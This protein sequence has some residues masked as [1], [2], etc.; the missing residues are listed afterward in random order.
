MWYNLQISGG[1][2][3]H[4]YSSP[5]IAIC[6]VG[7]W[8]SNHLR[9]FTELVGKEN[10]I[11]YDTSPMILSSLVAS[12]KAKVSTSL[13]EAI[14]FA[15][16]VVVSCPADRHT[17]IAEQA[18]L[19]GRSVFIEKPIATTEKDGAKIAKLAEEKDVLV[20]VDHILLHHP[21]IKIIKNEIS[22]GKLGNIVYVDMERTH[23]GWRV[24][25]E[26]VINSIALHDIYLVEDMF[27]KITD[28]VSASGIKMA[29]SKYGFDDVTA[30]VKT[31]TGT[32]VRIHAS[33]ATARKQR[34]ISIMGDN[35]TIEWNDVSVAGSGSLVLSDK[36][37]DNDSESLSTATG[38]CELP[39]VWAE[40]LKEAAKDFINSMV[41]GSPAKC[42][43]EDGTRAVKVVEAIRR[44]IK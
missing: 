42:S 20:A 26:D 24:H 33:W 29:R 15:D 27:G 36:Y 8:G 39:Y 3:S 40:P 10:I 34:Y 19:S 9:V 13:D 12:N 4:K 16:G 28:I 25:G 6:G 11:A 32:T 18:I 44:A 17:E 1:G 43:A 14:E 7:R 23:F 37:I 21:A 5:K 41:S 22:D 38:S 30:I 31:T 2:M 35:G